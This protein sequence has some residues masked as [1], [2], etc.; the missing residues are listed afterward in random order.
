MNPLSPELV[1]GT[2]GELLFQLRL[3]QYGVQAAPPLKDTGN[4]LIAV[5]GESFRAIQVK[6]T[7]GD[8]VRVDFD[9]TRQFHLLALAHLV[10]EGEMLH[11]DQCQLFLIPR[12]DLDTGRFRR[13]RLREYSLGRGL[14]DQLFR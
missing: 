7:T 9:R 10:G 5:R 13:E 6:T 2:V 11:L 1:T 3:L 8:D 4:D 14:V 12:G